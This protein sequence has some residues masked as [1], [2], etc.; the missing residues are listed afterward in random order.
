MPVVRS[1]D[2][3]RVNS[4]CVSGIELPVS[5]SRSVGDT[6]GPAA[7]APERD[8]PFSADS[9]TESKAPCRS[10]SH[11]D[12]AHRSAAAAAVD[13]DGVSAG[14]GVVGGHQDAEGPGIVVAPQ[15]LVHHIGHRHPMRHIDKHQGSAPPAPRARATFEPVAE[16]PSDRLCQDSVLAPELFVE[17][18]L[19]TGPGQ[20]ADTADAAAAGQDRLD[21]G[22]RACVAVPVDRRDLRAPPREGVGVGH[23]DR[24]SLRAVPSGI[25]DERGDP[26]VVLWREPDM[27][28]RTE[29]GGHLLG[30]EGAHAASGHP[31]DD[32]A[33]EETVGDRVISGRG[34]R[35]PCRG[36]PGQAIRGNG[37]LLILDAADLDSPPIA[38]VQLPV[39][40]PT[41]FHG[42]WI[43]T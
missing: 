14:D 2:C 1:Q 39:R 24:E 23:P 22:D 32:L 35:L 34:A 9:H 7:V 27:E 4:G 19:A 16:A 33:D 29:R 3:L 18:A 11:S 6:A 31:G 38:E 42:S 43:S 28:I 15:H 37:Y 12:N 13:Y 30:E 26:M 21:R 25:G 40:I 17:H 41:G 8:R 10:M 36:L 5:L 20:Q